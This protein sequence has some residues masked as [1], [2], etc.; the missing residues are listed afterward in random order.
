MLSHHTLENGSPKIHKMEEHPPSPPPPLAPQ[1]QSFWHS[2]AS[3]LTVFSMAPFLHATICL[4]QSAK[5]MSV[6]RLTNPI[7]L[8]LVIWFY[9]AYLFNS[10]KKNK[11]AKR[12]SLLWGIICIHLRNHCL[13]MLDFLFHWILKTRL[14]RFFFFFSFNAEMWL[15]GCPGSLFVTVWGNNSSLPA[16]VT[17]LRGLE[18]PL[19][20]LNSVSGFPWYP[21]PS[22]SDCVYKK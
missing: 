11:Q 6:Y 13:F 18:Q 19:L 20:E 12:G 17:F 16:T 21:W 15:L 22:Y 4:E 1:F 3:I 7:I 14:W 5:H 10:R 9:R 2:R 8:F